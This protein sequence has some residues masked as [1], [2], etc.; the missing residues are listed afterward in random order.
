VAEEIRRL[1]AV[2]FTDLA[3]YTALSH[4]DEPQALA[5]L[6]EHRQIVRPALARFGGREVKTMGDGFLVEF[7]SVVN[8]VRCAEE[9]QTRV[10]ER[11]QAMPGSSRIVLRIGIHLGDVVDS[12][13]DL[14][15]NAV[16]LAARIE[17]L[18]EPGGICVSRP[19]YDQV[20]NTLRLAMVSI[21]VRELKNIPDAIELYHVVLPWKA[22][23]P[24]RVSPAGRS[25]ARL[26][27]KGDLESPID[28]IVVLPFA[29]INPNPGDDFFSDGMT[30]EL[31]EKL[32]HV[33]GLRV[34]ARTTSMRYR[35]THESARAIG[36]SLGVGTVVEGSVRKSGSR[37]RI[38]VQLID[39]RSE[40]HLWSSS[41]DQILDDIFAIQDDISARIVAAISSRLSTEHPKT[42]IVLSAPHEA[43]ETT[44]TRAYTDFLHGQHLWHEKR[45]EDSIRQAL[46]FF[47]QALLRDPKLGRARIGIA[48]CHSWLGNEGVEP[49]GSAIEKAKEELETALRDNDQLAEAHSTLG[50]IFLSGDD[51]VGAKREANR[52]V[53]LNPNL[54]DPLRTLAQISAGEGDIANAVTLIETAHQLDP[55]DFN[56]VAFLGR[57]YFYSGRYSE[58]LA[59]WERTRQLVPYRTW[60]H[61]TEY[62]LSQGDFAK[63]KECLL[64]LDAIRP[65]DPWTYMYRGYLAARLGDRPEA[66]V[67]L[68]K[69][70]E[71]SQ[72]GSVTVFLIGYLRFAL[73]EVDAFF[74]SMYRARDIHAL[75]TLELMYSPLFVG[76]RSDPRYRDILGTRSLG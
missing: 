71:F 31:I 48:N 41:Y 70:E 28:R 65:T 64:Q 55:L 61:M 9:I 3:G 52:A 75:P 26:S 54:A 56:I 49:Y 38:T 47:E 10:H 39:A 25:D 43:P 2:M 6:E 29:S 50:S 18:A 7:G 59:H 74:E 34:I 21:G 37:V 67:M 4:E 35:T 57:L 63:V 24:A 68:E 72:K 42:A 53:E 73:G 11:N 5:L 76:A 12:G 8:A 69:L 22:E 14:Y 62:Y 45:S 17:P 16:N 36:R 44:D 23:E 32:S 20:R 13:G 66:A 30:E 51:L 58:A 15:G 1:A 33:A 19:V 60:A 27:S 46:Q 40:E